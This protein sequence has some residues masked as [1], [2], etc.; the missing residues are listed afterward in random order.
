[1]KTIHY[2]K[3]SDGGY[4]ARDNEKDWHV[5]IEPITGNKWR[6]KINYQGAY[7]QV[8]RRKLAQL[9]NTVQLMIT[10]PGSYENEWVV[11]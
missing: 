7:A 1:M 5:K 10:N 11:A 4:V 2:E 8:H 6:A 3:T 9:M